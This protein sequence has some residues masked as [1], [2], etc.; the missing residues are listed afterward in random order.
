MKYFLLFFSLTFQA[1]PADRIATFDLRYAQDTSGRWTS[2]VQITRS[3]LP[4]TNRPGQFMLCL[5][6]WTFTFSNVPHTRTLWITPA[7]WTN[8]GTH[9]WFQ[10]PHLATNLYILRP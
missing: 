7:G 2:T 4:L 8:R 10:V 5:T 3:A 6:N 9:S 1:I